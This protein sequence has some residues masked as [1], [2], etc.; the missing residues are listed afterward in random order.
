VPEVRLHCVP[1]ANV[2][3][4]WKDVELYM[5][6]AAIKG[7][8]RLD[9]E[10]LKKL[11]ETGERQLWIVQKGSCFVAAA[12]TDTFHEPFKTIIEFVA[13]GGRE[14]DEWVHF[15]KQIT[16][17]AKKDIGAAKSRIICRPGIMKKMEP[18]GYEIR[19]YVM[20]K[21]L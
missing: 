7:P 18:L 14:M 4:F 10:G 20:E 13:V 3:H 21:V 6:N 11:C 17:M 19:G 5:E 15:E 2:K 8:G 16:G 12:I 1:P 9:V